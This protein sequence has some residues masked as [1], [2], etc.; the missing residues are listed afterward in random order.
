M[1]WRRDVIY[2]SVLCKM[3]FILMAHPVEL[4]YVEIVYTQKE[5][6]AFTH[7]IPY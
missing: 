5:E 7:S 4:K 3:M 1:H 2:H 6:T